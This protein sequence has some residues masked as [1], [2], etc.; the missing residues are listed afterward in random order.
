MDDTD[1]KS[2]ALLRRSVGKNVS[3]FSCYEWDS[4]AAADFV[5]KKTTLFET[6]WPVLVHFDDSSCLRIYSE[7]S[8]TVRMTI[9]TVVE[10]FPPTVTTVGTVASVRIATG[11]VSL[12]EVKETPWA[13]TLILDRADPIGVALGETNLEGVIEMIPDSFLVIRDRKI[14]EHYSPDGSPKGAWGR[15]IPRY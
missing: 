3:G 9:E 12:L 7:V 13:A 11:Q 6:F 10:P 15:P 5:V 1:T 14:A 8:S 4:G 2:I